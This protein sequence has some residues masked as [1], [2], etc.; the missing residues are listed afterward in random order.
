MPINKALE[1][2]IDKISSCPQGSPTEKGD[3]HKHDVIQ[4]TQLK[5]K[6]NEQVVTGAQEVRG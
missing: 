6:K 2:E 4:K 3:K 5:K 1:I